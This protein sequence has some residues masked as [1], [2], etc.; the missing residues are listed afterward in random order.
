MK[1]CS[2]CKT[3]KD[4]SNFCKDSKSKDRLQSM[5]KRCKTD[6]IKSYYKKYPEKKPKYVYSY[7]SQDRVNGLKKYYKHRIHYNVARLVR[8]GL[9][10]F[11]KSQPTFDLVGYS[12]EELKSHLEKQFVSGMTWENYGKHGWHID[13]IVPRAKLPYD[14][15]E[16]PNFKLCWALN[17]LQPLWASDNWKKGDR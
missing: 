9:D 1:T 11:V 2:K 12:V 15:S 10:G 8:K 16:H 3:D 17:N 5:C 14:S 7:T 4:E 6:Y 13:H